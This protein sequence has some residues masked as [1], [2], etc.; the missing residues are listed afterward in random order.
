MSLSK[1]DFITAAAIVTAL[2]T[3]ELIEQNEN[4]VS[5]NTSLAVEQGFRQLFSANSK[6]FDPQDWRDGI[7]ND[8]KKAV[9]SY[10][11]RKAARDAEQKAY[12]EQEKAYADRIAEIKAEI[13]S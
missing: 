6:A 10:Y 4:G 13:A 12:D 3:D 9:V 2:R 8:T 7:D 1:K 11:E 5:A